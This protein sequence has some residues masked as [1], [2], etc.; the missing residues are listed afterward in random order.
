M[1]KN[2]QMKAL[3]GQHPQVRKHAIEIQLGVETCTTE[4]IIRWMCVLKQ[5]KRKA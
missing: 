5:I 4:H 3:E 2:E 1:A